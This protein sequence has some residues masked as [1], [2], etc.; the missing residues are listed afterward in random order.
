M[1]I[2][3]LSMVVIASLKGGVGKTNT[4]W[5]VMSSFFASQNMGFQIFEIDDNN[6]GFNFQLSNIIN[7]NNCKTVKTD[8]P[9]VAA[10][11]VLET[12]AT[13]DKIIV[14]CGG[15]NDT[16]AAINLVKSVGDDV[17]KIW[18]V[19]F[20]RNQDDFKLALETV[21]LINDPKNTYLA[22]NAYTS[23]T[24]H[25]EFD[26]FFK[27][28]IKNYIE[29][30]YSNL[31]S[32]AQTNQQSIFDLAQISQNMNKAEAKKIFTEQFTQ[33]EELDKDAFKAAFNDFLK[34]ELA[35]DVVKQINQSFLTIFNQ[36]EQEIA[37]N[38]DEEKTRAKKSEKITK[39]EN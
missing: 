34:S 8:D 25:L 7:Q 19:P 1:K 3:D 30:P 28:D 32:H 9:E 33:N 22:L 26:W 37:K 39:E 21:E 35:V 38:N 13:D 27:L 2:T 11:L 18:I 23:K 31:F 12:I 17:A 24:K 6:N 5:Q 16:R 15:G 14:D 20:D 4:G 10:D 36:K 29:I